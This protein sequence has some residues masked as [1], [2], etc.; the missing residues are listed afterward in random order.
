[1]CTALCLL[2]TPLSADCRHTQEDFPKVVRIAHHRLL[3][4]QYIEHRT[5]RLC[6]PLVIEETQFYTQSLGSN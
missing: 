2:S 6:Q 4:Q 3:S 5:E 1:M